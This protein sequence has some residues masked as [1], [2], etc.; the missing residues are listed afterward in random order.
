MSQI[1]IKLSVDQI[2]RIIAAL[3]GLH[4]MDEQNGFE[5]EC[6]RTNEVI[7]ILDKATVGHSLRVFC[8]RFLVQ[9]RHNQ[10]GG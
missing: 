2:E 6:K 10:S 1:K 3:Q 4:D 9:L 7:G 8:T 5:D